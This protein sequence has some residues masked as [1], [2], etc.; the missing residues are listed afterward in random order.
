M[1]GRQSWLGFGYPFKPFPQGSNANV[2]GSGIMSKNIL[3]I[4]E[5]VE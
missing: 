1:L 4:K 5:V 3:Y 2:R